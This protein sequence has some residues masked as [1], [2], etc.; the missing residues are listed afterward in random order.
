MSPVQCARPVTALLLLSLLATS[1]FAIPYRSTDTQRVKL[2]KQA[3]IILM[4]PGVAAAARR[5]YALRAAIVRRADRRQWATQRGGLHAGPMWANAA[6]LISWRAAGP[7]NIGGRVN[8]ILT[9]PANPQQLFIGTSN[10]GIWK[11]ADGGAH[12]VSVGNFLASL[13]VSALARLPDGALLAGTG[14]QFNSPRRGIGILKSSDQGVTWQ[15]LASTDPS[16]HSDWGWYYVNDIA[17]NPNA[18]I[19]A[20]LGVAGNP[21]SGGIYR[22][23]DGGRTF[24]RVQAGPSLDVE[25]D[26]NDAN[27]AIAEFENGT[28]RITAD[29]GLS[30]SAPIALVVGGGRISLD[31]AASMPGWIYAVVADDPTAGA[32]ELDREFE[33]TAGLAPGNRPDYDPAWQEHLAYLLGLVE[34][35]AKTS[36]RGVSGTLY[37]SKDGGRTWSRRGAPPVG[38]LCAGEVGSGYCQGWYDNVVWVDP[39]DAKRVVAGGIDL[40]RTQDGGISWARI[41]DWRLVP[42]SPHADHHALAAASNYDG[43]THTTFYDGNDG[44]VYA[45]FDIASVRTGNGWEKR[46]NGLAATEFYDVAGHAGV[47]SSWNGGIVPIIAGSQDNGTLLH[48]ANSTV[49]RNWVTIFGGDGGDVAVDPLDG[50]YLYGEYVYL[51]I[52]QSVYGGP[53]GQWLNPLPPDAGNPATANFIAPF[54]LD[55]TDSNAIFAGGQSLWYG[56]G[57]KDGSLAWRSLNGATLPKD[58]IIHCIAVNVANHNDVWTGFNDGDIYRSTNAL[59]A[60][61]QWEQAGA[62]VLPRKLPTDIHLV[63]GA[64]TTVYIAYWSWAD[65]DSLWVSHD[66]GANWINIAAGLPAVPVHAVTTAPYSDRMIFAGTSTGL[67]AST[68]G[69]ENWSTNSQGPANVVVTDLGWFDPANLVL[70]AGTYGRGAFLGEVQEIS[71]NPLPSLTGLAPSSAVAGSTGFTLRVNGTD[72]IPSSVV[73]WNNRPLATTYISATEVEAVVPASALSSAG[74]INVTAKTPLPGGGTSNPAA[75][76]VNNP[77][78]VIESLSPASA[79]AGD[80]ELTLDITGSGFTTASVVYWDGYALATTLQSA[81]KLSAVVPAARLMVAGSLAITVVNPPPG[82]GTSAG[83]R[84][85]VEQFGGGTV[86]FPLLALWLAGFVL[87]RRRM[88]CSKQTSRQL[89]R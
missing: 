77:V 87:M 48:A 2:R 52:F 38:L 3:P 59:S 22:S 69:G 35:S 10:G 55:P 53:G 70:L 28:V 1:A 71:L 44:G 29:A 80:D 36:S 7:D 11:S 26:P 32:A 62:G 73:Q 65:H 12:W 40:Y 63:P 74:T 81:E 24:S 85:T 43:V 67:Y 51:G 82:G 5:A 61:P 31:Y 8:A 56:T 23:D 41:S 54:E 15:P 21:N 39:T 18:V 75:F 78:P 45:A 4:H 17:V 47:S 30:W 64:S 16:I 58:S 86:S 89:C 88:A 57:L 20:A 66:N 9:N 33:H 25:F 42:D 27:H 84:F 37:R 72:F 79:M 60:T 83:V 6:D 50:N 13:A 19:L 34:G 49:S 14:D 46:N 68:N 76:T